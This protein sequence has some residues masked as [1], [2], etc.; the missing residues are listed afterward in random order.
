MAFLALGVRRGAGWVPTRRLS[1]RSRF[2]TMRPLLRTIMCQSLNAIRC[3][4][5]APRSAN[6]FG[7]ILVPRRHCQPHATTIW[8]SKVLTQ[9]EQGERQALCKRT[10]HE[11]RTVGEVVDRLAPGRMLPGKVELFLRS[12]ERLPLAHAALQR[13]HLAVGKHWPGW[14]RCNSTKIVVA[15]RTPWRSADN[16]GNT[17]ADLNLNPALK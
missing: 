10:A 7:K 2:T 17:Q 15:S 16:S 4:V 14:R 6:Q 13:M 3:S 12:V 9:F 5:T 11:V 1:K 8:S